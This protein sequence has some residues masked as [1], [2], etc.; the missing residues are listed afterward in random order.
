MSNSSAPRSR[1]RWGTQLGFLVA[2]IGSAVGLGNIWRFPGVA[3]ENGG[4]A[5]ILPYLVAL[6]TAGIPFL[7]FD[8]ALGHR[9][10]GSSPTVFRRI[11]KKAEGIGWFHVAVC[12]VI[13]TYYAVIVAWSISY[14]FYSTN[15]SWGND[16][17]D[18][19]VKDY[20]EVGDPGFSLD[21]V[22]QVIL[23]L[24]AVWVIVLV[25]I[26]LGIQ[27]GLEKAN[28]FFIPLL[29]ILFS[30]LVI[31][32]L[33]LPGASN[34]LNAF[35]TPDWKALANPSVWVSAYSQIFYSLSVGFGI[36]LTYASYLPRKSNLGPVALVAG[37]A[38]SSFEILAGIGVFSTLGFMAFEQ[39]VNISDLEGISGVSLSFMT[40]PKIISAMTGGSIFGVLFF[41]SLTI[42]G[43]TSLISLVQVVSAAIQDKF[44]IGKVQA[45]IIV[46]VT[47]GFVSVVLFSSVNGINALDVVDNWINSIALIGVAVF[48]VIYLTYGRKILRELR[49]HVSYVSSFT[50]GKWWSFTVGVITPAVLI[51]ILLAT[52]WTL[53]TSGY[54]EYP[55]SFQL[56]FGWGCVLFAFIFTAVFT[57]VP[58]SKHSRFTDSTY[59]PWITASDLEEWAKKEGVK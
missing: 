11:H 41:L 6:L 56:I 59:Q 8:Y 43:I 50:L 33:F 47:A 22:L 51:Y 35:F 9:Y 58:W 34:G 55:T 5:F 19:F 40:F 21:M 44:A 17:V 30:F 12:F 25:L 45:A 10:Q 26:G 15:Q 49:L 28:R 16:P 18:F 53:A 13:M 1:E 38:N 2:A 14:L 23:P 29:V 20:L 4:G 27:K 24:I 39:G 31:Y 37:F 7:I 57:L 32:S 54:G 36:M 48:A 52:V 3:Y 46:S 42:A